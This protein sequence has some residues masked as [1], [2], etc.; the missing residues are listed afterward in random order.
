MLHDEIGLHA[1]FGSL[2]DGEGF[3]FERLDRARGRQV[4]GDV[5]AAFDFESE[6]LDDAAALIL[7]VYVDGRG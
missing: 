7:G 2:L 6:R 5:G 1:E 4:D 3:G